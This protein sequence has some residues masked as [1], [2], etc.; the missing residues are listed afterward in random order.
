MQYW[1]AIGR[2]NGTAEVSAK[3]ELRRDQ[4]VR[5]EAD[6]RRSEVEGRGGGALPRKLP[7]SEHGRQRRRRALRQAVVRG[8]VAAPIERATR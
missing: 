5:R 1:R 4:I 3:A 6:S 7:R 2:P 8:E